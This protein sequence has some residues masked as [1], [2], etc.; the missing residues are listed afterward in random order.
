MFFSGFA[1]RFG[2]ELARSRSEEADRAERQNALES[3]VLQHLASS[4]DPEIASHAITGLLDLA[5]PQ[6]KAPGLSGWLGKNAAHPA[7]PTIRQLIQQGRMVEDQPE[8][9][10]GLQ[11]RGGLPGDVGEAISA[12][13]RAPGGSAAEGPPQAVAPQGGPAGPVPTPSS[14][15]AASPPPLAPF[16]PGD[17]YRPATQKRVAREVMLSPDQQ[18]ERTAAAHERGTL[19]VR[20]AAYDQFAGTPGKQSLIPG[21]DNQTSR[22]AGEV[23]DEHGNWFKQ[24]WVTDASGAQTLRRTPI[25]KAAVRPTGPQAQA[26]QRAQEILATNEGLTPEQALQMAN[27]EGRQATLDKVQATADTHAIRLG[28]MQAMVPATIAAWQRVN[29]TVPMTKAQATTEAYRALNTA[30][31]TLGGGPDVTVEDITRFADGLLAASS[32]RRGAMVTPTRAD[33]TQP[34]GGPPSATAP[35][36]AAPTLTGAVPGDLTATNPH[37]RQMGA[38]QQEERTTAQQILTLGKE[39]LQEGDALKWEGVGG[40]GAGTVGQFLGNTFGDLAGPEQQAM[41]ARQTSLRNKINRIFGIIGQLQGGRTFTGTEL[42]IIKG[43]APTINQSIPALKANLAALT[44]YVQER[45][46]R[47]EQNLERPGKPGGG[48]APPPGPGTTPAPAAHPNTAMA[49]GTEFRGPD[50]KTY[51]KTGTNPDGSIRGRLKAGG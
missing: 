8:H 32:G 23:Q 34:L 14:A 22:A 40:M 49:D 16:A 47:Q 36:P 5:G 7:L 35:P 50:G 25:S 20:A 6:K 30:R 31:A 1:G 4:P 17:T 42:Q 12:P 18:A 38:G 46:D 2:E 24:D 21:V 29:G 48:S 11:V 15:K 44:S 9:V 43:Y 27:A 41:I 39:V 45:L 51:V 19:G 10:P 3:S 28:Q 26:L 13:Q 33:Q 37:P